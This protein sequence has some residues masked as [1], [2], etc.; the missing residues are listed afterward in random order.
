SLEVSTARL[1][2]LGG[3]PLTFEALGGGA[4]HY[5]ARLRFARR[6]LPAAPVESGFFVRRTARSLES[7]TPSTPPGTFAAGDLIAVEVEVV[8]PSPRDFV[9]LESPLPGG[10][11]PADADLRL[12]G[13]WLRNIESSPASRRELRDDRVVYFVDHLRAGITRYRYVARA[14]TP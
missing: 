14:T 2:G 11:E 4:L 6:E 7:S 3:K 10:F 8:T 1:L 5:E 12:G 13:A 9:V